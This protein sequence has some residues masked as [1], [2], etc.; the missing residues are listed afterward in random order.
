[1]HREYPAVQ[2]IERVAG[3]E[4]ATAEVLGVINASPA[5]SRR[6]FETMVEKAMRC[7]SLA[8][9]LSLFQDDDH[10]SVVATCGGAPGLSNFVTQSVPNPPGSVASLMRG[11]EAV[12]HIPDITVVGPEFRSP[13][14]IAMIELGQARTALWVGLQKDGGARGFFTLY[15]DE[16]RPFSDRQIALVQNFAAQAVVAM[17]NARL[18][19]EVA[20]IRRNCASRSTTWPPAWPCSTRAAACGVEQEFPG[21]ARSSRPRSSPSRVILTTT[22]LPGG[23]GEFGATDVDAEIARMH[24]RFADHYS[25]ERTRPDG[26]D[27][28][29]PPQPGPRRRLVLIYSDVTERKRS[30][31]E[32]RTARDAAEAAP[33]N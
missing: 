30:E 21:S 6:V 11:G 28:R 18:L 29:G 33:R 14:I 26:R 1:L 5:I 15:R 23:A 9:A 17:E 4:T 7:A 31:A 24:A 3:A 20:S 2:R 25:F 10:Y 16:V 8:C 27:R 19:V 32:I 12:I 13:G 22:P